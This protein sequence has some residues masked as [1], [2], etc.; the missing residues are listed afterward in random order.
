MKSGKKRLL[1]ACGVLAFL[2]LLA[3]LVPRLA[4]GPWNA[5]PMSEEDAIRLTNSGLALAAGKKYEE[6]L[7][8][9]GQ[10]ERGLRSAQD[11]LRRALAAQAI[12]NRGVALQEMNEPRKAIRIYLKVERKYGADPE[13]RIRIHSVM[14]A[15]NRGIALMTMGKYPQAISVFQAVVMASEAGQTPALLAPRAS[16]A[17]H[18]LLPATPGANGRDDAPKTRAL[19]ARARLN[20]GTA[21]GQSGKHEAA[22][23][24]FAGIDQ[25]YAADA[26]LVTRELVAHALYNRGIALSMQGQTREAIAILD[27]VRKRYRDAGEFLTYS[28][29]VR[30]KE[31][32]TALSVGQVAAPA[33]GSGG[34]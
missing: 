5:T 24:E 18:A 4:D 1:A 28:W 25:E 34:R 30:A 23:S 6:S 8:I 17:G 3:C 20:L 29:S 26:D 14:A 19:V 31:A 13:P 9:W 11:P 32:R 33:T 21:L 7:E 27:L 16:E 10:L 22:V 2:A 12:Y 15:V